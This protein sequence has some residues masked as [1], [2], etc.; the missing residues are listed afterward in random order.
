MAVKKQENL[1][2]M[3]RLELSTFRIKFRRV[4]AWWGREEPATTVNQATE[5]LEFRGFIRTLHVDAGI[6]I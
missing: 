5:D 3:P 2:P 1:M 6:V 4:F